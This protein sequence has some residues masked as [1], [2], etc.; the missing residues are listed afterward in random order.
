M[1][2]LLPEDYSPEQKIKESSIEFIPGK[3]YK[4]NRWY[5]KYKEHVNDI[6]RSSEQIDSCK[7]YSQ[8]EGSFGDRDS[9]DKKI[10]LLDLSEIQE[11]L[12]EG[13]PDKVKNFKIEVGKWYS[14]NWDWFGKD[15]TVI[16]KI[17]R[18]REDDFIISWRSYLWKD[19]D[20]SNEDG[21]KFKDI[22]NIKELSIEEVQSYLPNGH[23]DK[24]VN[25]KF[26]IGKWYKWYQKN[27]KDY[28]YGKVKTINTETDTLVMS[29]WI[30]QCTNYMYSGTFDLL[31]AEQIQE[32]SVEEV[33]EFLPNSHPDKITSS[34]FKKGEY[35][36]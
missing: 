24:I 29:P 8:Q 4:Y 30:M 3:W 1:Y 13:H 5:I 20:Y 35:D 34:E 11:Y 9:D 21:Y 7:K 31:K 12:P 19:E 32:I 28:H 17:K 16:V 22:S 27:H 26:E 14:F 18:V 2:E 23:P 15:R 36:A 10:L 25:Q 6:W 33:Q